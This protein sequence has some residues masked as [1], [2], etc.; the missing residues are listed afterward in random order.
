MGSES[1]ISFYRIFLSLSLSPLG[2]LLISPANP[3]TRVTTGSCLTAAANA[4]VAMPDAFLTLMP[5]NA[6]VNDPE[7]DT[8]YRLMGN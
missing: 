3:R 7:N 1:S 5:A 2:N 4:E 8:L 6:L